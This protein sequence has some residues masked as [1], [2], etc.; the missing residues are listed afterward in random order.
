MHRF[1]V[2]VA[3]LTVVAA[4]PASA[5]DIDAVF[6][7]FGLLGTWSPN[8]SDKSQPRLTFAGGSK[9]TASFNNPARD[10]SGEASVTAAE[11]VSDEKVSVTVTPAKRNGKSV[12]PKS[13]ESRP[14]IMAIEKVG[15][16]IKGP[17]G[18][19]LE[20]CAN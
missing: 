2:V 12:D 17:S 7:A 11:R 3:L 18:P 6:K 20:R 16:K 10:E 8:C 19:T 1:A 13:S 4:G 14:Q 5:Q 9:P 15:D